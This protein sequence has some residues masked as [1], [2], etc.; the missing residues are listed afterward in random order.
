LDEWE[1]AG[2]LEEETVVHSAEP[3]ARVVFGGAPPSLQEAEAATFELN[4][5][6]QK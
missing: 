4:D 3:V 6:F 2:G 5:A 1:F